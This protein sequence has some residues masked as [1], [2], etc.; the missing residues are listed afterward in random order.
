[1]KSYSELIKIDSFE[2]R[3]RYLQTKN[4]VGAYTYGG[5]RILN[6][7]FYRSKLWR[8]TRS[9]IIL[10]DDG[11]DLAHPSYPI[12]G[13]IYI[14][15]INPISIN[16]ILNNDSSLV[17]PENLVCVSFNTHQMIH[18]ATDISEPYAERTKNDTIPWR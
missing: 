3:V 2:D 16:D 11:N 7:D 12:A 13:Q 10:R 17:D 18:Y 4:Q 1:M 5:A 15:H 9:K 8:S 14:H 6:Q